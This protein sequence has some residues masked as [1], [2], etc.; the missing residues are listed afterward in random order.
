MFRARLQA[1]VAR[2]DEGAV[3]EAIDPRIRLGFDGS[4]GVDDFKKRM[5]GAGADE[6]W[7]ELGTVLALGGSFQTQSSFAA[8]FTYSR[9]PDDIDSFACA[10]VLGDRVRL[11]S[12]PSPEALSLGVISYSIVHIVEPGEK[13][14]RWQRV[15]FGGR[16]GY[17]ARE[18]VRSP[19]GYRALFNL[20]EGRWRMTAFVAGD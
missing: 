6:F 17:V 4:G 20:S 12:A 10:V 5:S 13:S 19:I 11:R 18:Y 14:D 1:A 16:T 9:W 2:R 7:S 3:L 8:P 15:Q